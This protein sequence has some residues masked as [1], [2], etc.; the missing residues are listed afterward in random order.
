[1]GPALTTSQEPSQ[2]EEAL[3]LWGSGKE[4]TSHD[5]SV[6]HCSKTLPIPVLVINSPPLPEKIRQ[7]PLG[8]DHSKVTG[9]QGHRWKYSW[10]RCVHQRW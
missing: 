10:G 4:N 3:H 5:G 7:K 2:G 8:V 9:G 1:M 6:I